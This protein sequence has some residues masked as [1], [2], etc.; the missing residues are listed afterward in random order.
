[1]EVHHQLCSFHC[2]D[3]EAAPL[4]LIHKSLGQFPVDPISDEA[5]DC[6]VVRE[7]SL[8]ISG[9]IAITKQYSKSAF[10]VFYLS[11]QCYFVCVTFCILTVKMT[12]DFLDRDLFLKAGVA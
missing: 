11:T 9:M 7:L 6:R 4:A 2:I 5:D 1:M 8:S 10:Y 3:L 12:P